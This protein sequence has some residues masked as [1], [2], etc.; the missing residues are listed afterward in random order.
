MIFFIALILVG[1]VIYLIVY[2][3][4]SSQKSITLSSKTPISEPKK[5]TEPLY[6]NSLRVF[7]AGVHIASR[8]KY[9]LN[10]GWD[11]MPVDLEPEPKNKHDKEAIAVKHEGKLIG[12][13][14]SDKTHLIHPILSKSYE[15]QF[16]S[17]DEED[18]YTNPG[19]THLTVYL[20]IDYNE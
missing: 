8:K 11:S 10:N 14:P 13:I 12:Y 15:A 4:K 9:I 5:N 17:M 18:S 2:K 7:L 1:Y 16:D 20:R 3:P 6:N 19:E